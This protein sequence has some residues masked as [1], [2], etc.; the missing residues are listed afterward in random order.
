L[1]F[2]EAQSTFLP[3]APLRCSVKLTCQHELTVY[4]NLPAVPQSWNFWFHEVSWYGMYAGT[5]ITSSA[6]FKVK[7]EEMKPVEFI[8]YLTKIFCNKREITHFL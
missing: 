6:V 8:F 4:E 7:D 1:H 5:E 3:S 2:T